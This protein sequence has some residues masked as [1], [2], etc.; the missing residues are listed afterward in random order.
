M[1]HLTFDELKQILIECA[2]QDDQATLDAEAIDTPFGDLGYDSLAVLEAAAVA[3]RRYGVAIADDDVQAVRTP[4]DLLAT[5]NGSLRVT[6][7]ASAEEA[8]A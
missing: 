7:A 5:V 3:G 8:T 6:A 1:S 2:G 4:R